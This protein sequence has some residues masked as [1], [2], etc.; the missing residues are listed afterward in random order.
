MLSEDDALDFLKIRRYIFFLIA[1]FPDDCL[2]LPQF[3]N[4][5]VKILRLK[6]EK[7]FANINVHNLI[8]L[9]DMSIITFSYNLLALALQ[10][11]TFRK[12]YV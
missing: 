3:L 12:K 10:N 1:P 2:L 5:G 6:S 4:H 9:Q 7:Q 11:G 8:M